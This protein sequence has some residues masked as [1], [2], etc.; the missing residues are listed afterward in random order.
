MTETQALRAD[1]AA[2]ALGLVDCDVHPQPGSIEELASYL[3]PALRRQAERHGLFDG[4]KLGRMWGPHYDWGGGI[5]LDAHPTEGESSL[6]LVRRQLLDLYGV[7]V[8]ILNFP[9]PFD[10]AGPQ[11]CSDGARAVNDWL[12]ERWLEPEPR[13]LGS[14]V[15]PWEWPELAVR[16]I[17]RRA[18]ERGW[19]QVLMPG[20]AVEP[21]G[22]PRYWPIYEA[23][24]AHGFPVASHIGYYDPHRGTGWPSFTFEHHL[25]FALSHRRQLLNL[26]CEGLFEH[27]PGVRIVLIEGGAGWAASLRWALDSAF[28]LL[29]DEVGLQRRPSEHFDQSVWFTTQPIEEPADP[30]D[31]VRSI[32]HGRL[33]ER[34]LF[35][36][37]YPH[38][39]F[40]SPKQSLPRSLDAELRGRILAG[41]ACRLYGLPR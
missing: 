13:L 18:G 24:T 21:L 29:G 33:A 22:S 35:S 25:G 6:D 38:W 19:A 7:D 9:S 2:R 8:A 12:G 11:L 27:V 37:D 4:R 3:T 30:D 34:L 1:A 31:F 41:N 36:T 20:E 14:F 5:R 32:Q 26:F 15:V 28:E 10:R 39:D 17:A 40:D 23:A 16:E